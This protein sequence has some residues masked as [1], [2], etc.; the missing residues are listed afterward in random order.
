MMNSGMPIMEMADNPVIHDVEGQVSV[1]QVMMAQTAAPVEEP[2]SGKK[3][4]IRRPLR[5]WSDIPVSS[6]N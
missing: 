3:Q 6:M 1:G 4:A 2:V 5:I